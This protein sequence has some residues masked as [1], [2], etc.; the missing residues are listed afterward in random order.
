MSNTT[1]EFLHQASSKVDNIVTG[2]RAFISGLKE[3]IGK[4]IWIVGEKIIRTVQKSLD[5]FMKY[6]DDVMAKY[7]IKSTIIHNLKELGENKIHHILA[8][9]HLWKQVV[10]NPKDWNQVS[11]VIE[12]VLSQGTETTYKTVFQKSLKFGNEEVVVTY[13]KTNGKYL[14]SDAWVVN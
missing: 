1:V 12:K 11:Q 7:V 2:A 14:I 10:S 5:D 6:V 3:A 9:K 4:I 13:V 8:D